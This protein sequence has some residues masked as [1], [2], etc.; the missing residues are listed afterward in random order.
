MATPGWIGARSGRGGDAWGVDNNAA[1]GRQYVAEGKVRVVSILREAVTWLKDEIEAAG[2]AAPALIEAAPPVRAERSRKV[3][4][5]HGHDG[6]A[7]HAVA[8]F[9]E[10]LDLD[11]V[12]LHEQANEGRTIIE[13]VE[14]YGDDVGFA[15]VLLTP[16]DDGCKKGGELRSRPRQ[17]V[18]MELGYFIGKLSRKHVCA[19]KTDD[20]IELPSDIL[21]VVYQTFEPDSHDWKMA[22]GKELKAAGYKIDFN[23]VME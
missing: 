22:L 12:I 17:N 23:K 1:E 16:D 9:V 7:K 3:F 19:L 5:V 20:D 14:A 18:I 10:S 21:G 15:I 8:R 6:A 13:K 2:L 4:I 11:A